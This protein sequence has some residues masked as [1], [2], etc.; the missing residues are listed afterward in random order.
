M[1]NL[2]VVEYIH[3]YTTYTYMI[4]NMTNVLTSVF[5][6]PVGTYAS[7]KLT[8]QITSKP[9]I[10]LPAGAYASRNVITSPFEKYKAQ[11]AQASKAGYFDTPTEKVSVSVKG[12]TL[13]V[14]RPSTKKYTEVQYPI[15]ERSIQ[16]PV[17]Q[18]IPTSELAPISPTTITSIPSTS[19][20]NL[21]L[22]GGLAIAALLLLKK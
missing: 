5:G 17:R 1:S 7:R 9:L 14:S 22:Y 3:I 12:K 20:N 2:Y 4:R 11:I 21:L 6:A 18:V 19:T 16:P 13:K 15:P 8:T 10:V